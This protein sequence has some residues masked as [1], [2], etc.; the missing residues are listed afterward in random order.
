[1]RIKGCLR[2]TCSLEIKADD[3]PE[4]S[5]SLYFKSVKKKKICFTRKTKQ[6]DCYRTY[7]PDLKIYGKLMNVR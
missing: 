3:E 4:I 5:L 7:L 6:K 1:M 2:L